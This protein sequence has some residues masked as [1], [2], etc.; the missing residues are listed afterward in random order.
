M[1]YL[2]SAKAHFATADRTQTQTEDHP[3]VYHSSFCMGFRNLDPYKGETSTFPGATHKMAEIRNTMSR[4][5]SG[6]RRERETPGTHSPHPKDSGATWFSSDGLL[7]SPKNMEMG[8][9]CR[10]FAHPNPLLMVAL[11]QRCKVVAPTTGRPK[12]APPLRLRRQHEP[13]GKHSGQIL[14]FRTQLENS[15]PR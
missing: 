1:A 11:F 12:R 8:W 6:A 15:G 14:F 5:L 7:H 4:N 10:T 9:T 3:F 13:M 2:Q